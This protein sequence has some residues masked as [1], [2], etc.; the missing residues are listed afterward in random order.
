MALPASTE[1]PGRILPYTLLAMTFVTGLVDATSYLALGRIFTANMTGNIVILGFAIAGTPG[2]SIPRSV[3]ALAAFCAG[4]ILGGRIH[5]RGRRQS[6]AVEEGRVGCRHA[7]RCGGRL[8][9]DPILGISDAGDC[10]GHL[11]NLRHRAVSSL[12]PVLAR[13]TPTDT[14]P[15]VVDRLSLG[16]VEI[17]KPLAYSSLAEACQPS[18]KAILLVHAGEPY[19]FHRR[20]RSGGP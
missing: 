15:K 9:A 3:T 10:R 16:R 18:R 8:A 20:R 6:A 11:R 13:M 14:H 1:G 17:G 4:A 19:D 12:A 2:L 5:F 7:H